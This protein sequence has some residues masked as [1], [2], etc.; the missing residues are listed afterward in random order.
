M[1]S[2]VIDASVMA[3]QLLR[4]E[5]H[6]HLAR[7]IMEQLEYEDMIVPRIFWYEIHHVLLKAKRTKRINQVDYDACLLQLEEEFSP[8]TDDGHNVRKL[9]NLAEQ[10]NLS[11]YDAGYLE[12]A[13]RNKAGLATFDG[14]LAKAAARESVKNPANQFDAI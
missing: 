7:T 13:L 10:H 9:I 4:D 14:P 2:I 1:R 12:T 5:E 3:A 6:S 8:S 11:V